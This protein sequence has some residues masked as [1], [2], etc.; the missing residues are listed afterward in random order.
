[1]SNRLVLVVLEVADLERSAA[2]YRDAFGVALE[3]ADHRD[4]VGE[5]RWISGAHASTSWHDGAYLHFALYAA[6]SDERSTGAQVGFT[7]DDIDAAHARAVAA[8]AEVIHAPRPEPWGATARYR[9]PDG[10]IVSLTQA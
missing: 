9:D 5:D 7:C 10:N 2:L 3:G 1:M 4:D 6:K 8:G